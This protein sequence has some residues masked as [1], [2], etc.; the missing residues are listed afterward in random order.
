MKP[1]NNLINLPNLLTISIFNNLRQNKCINFYVYN[2][3]KNI[4]EQFSLIIS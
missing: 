2:Y 4:L 3:L 1:L